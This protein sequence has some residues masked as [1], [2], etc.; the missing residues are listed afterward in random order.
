[1]YHCI[2]NRYDHMYTEPLHPNRIIRGDG[3]VLI[4]NDS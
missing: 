3:Y 4:K 2:M 1:M